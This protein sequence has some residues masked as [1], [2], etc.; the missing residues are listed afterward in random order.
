VVPT[1][2][3]SAFMMP[4]IANTQNTPGFSL[5]GY[6]ADLESLSLNVSNDIQYITLI[7]SESVKLLDRKPAGQL[8]F[9]APTV[10]EKDY[11]TL[12]ANNTPGAMSF[13][14]GSRNGFKVSFSAPSVQLGNPSYA[15]SKGVR[16]VSGPFTCNPISGDDEFYLDIK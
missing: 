6:S 13:D 4:Q 7:G 11:W 8:Q 16:F 2:D 14:H 15:D 9:E 3:F 1:V 12:V 10:A 5:F